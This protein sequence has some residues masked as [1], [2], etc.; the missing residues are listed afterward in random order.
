VLHGSVLHHRP[1][2]P[3]AVADDFG[4]AAINSFGMVH[5]HEFAE[6]IVSSSPLKG[7]TDEGVLHEVGQ[8]NRATALRKAAGQILD[9]Y[10]GGVPSTRSDGID[11]TVSVKFEMGCSRC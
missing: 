11:I 8:V 4:S 3:T 1:N 7:V 9:A 2:A 6:V 10:V 5:F